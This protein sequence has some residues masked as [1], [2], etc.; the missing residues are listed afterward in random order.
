MP[1]E[2]PDRYDT[3]RKSS[4]P[5][6]TPI[7]RL[8]A[9]VQRIKNVSPLRSTVTVPEYWY[10]FPDWCPILDMSLPDP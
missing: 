5:I 8:P 2:S 10:R 7:W 1:I 6:P 3:A 9:I 4:L